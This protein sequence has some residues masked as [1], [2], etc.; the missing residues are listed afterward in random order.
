MMH[1][2]PHGQMSNARQGR[3]GRAVFLAYRRAPGARFGSARFRAEGLIRAPGSR[4]CATMARGCSAAMGTV[5]E[6]R[7]DYRTMEGL[8]LA[9]K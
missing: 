8:D 7:N 9:T 4:R 5:A 6:E 1:F 2:E 3:P